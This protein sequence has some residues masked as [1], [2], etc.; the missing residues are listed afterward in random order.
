MKLYLALLI[1]LAI[2]VGCDVVDAPYVKSVAPPADTSLQDTST[3]SV[4]TGALQNVLIEDYT[5]H[6]CGF[7]PEA[8]DI[9][10][11]IYQKHPGRVVVAAIHAGGFARPNPP[12]Y[13]ADY[14][15]TVGT[16]LDETF[17]ISRAGNPNGL[18][19]RV[20]T[21][22][23]FIQG[24]NVWDPLTTQLLGQSPAMKLDMS[25]TYYP[26]RRTIVVTVSGEYLSA[27]TPDYMLC[28]W[29]LESGIIGEQ[30]DYRVTPS[31]VK[32]Y[33]FE[34][35]LRASFNGTWGDTLSKQAVAT[36]TT[37]TRILRYELPTT[38]DWNTDN[39]ELV[40]FVH[41]HQT[42]KEVVQVIKQKL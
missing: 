12:S 14:R 39:C 5:G 34:H 2:I 8:A 22:G 17:R 36:G 1:T 42:T 25:H 41:R 11:V 18:L 13:P 32:D 28:V 35:V 24:Q 33:L 10:T 23:R 40:V 7:C 31:Y 15:T 21:G 26:D 4:T 38:V 9:A 3:V 16:A 19:N 27:G 6:T 30:T 20:T 37:F 29:L